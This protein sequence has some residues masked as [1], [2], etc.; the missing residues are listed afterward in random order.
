MYD[1]ES[2]LAEAQAANEESWFVQSIDVY[3]RTDSTLSLRMY[4][5]R[6][7]FVQAFIGEVTGSLYF[8]LVERNQRIYGID[9]EADRWHVHPFEDPSK[10]ESFLPG[11]GPT[12]LLAFMSKVEQV[13]VEGDLL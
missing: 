13:L 8:A 11:L 5:R 9:R 3:E 10:H 2:L 6:D 4:I 12:P 1:S 7:L